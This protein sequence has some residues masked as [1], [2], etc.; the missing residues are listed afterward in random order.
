MKRILFFALL[1]LLPFAIPAQN[2]ATATYRKVDNKA[3]KRGETLRYRIHYGAINAGEADLVVDNSKTMINGRPTLH[4]VGTGESKGAFDW[5]FKVRDRYE[6]YLDEEALMPWLFL[7][8]VDEG[9]YKINQ[10][11][12]Y[13]HNSG[14]VKSNGKSITVP[15]Y[16]QDMLSSFYYARTMDFSKAKVG[17]IFSVKTFIDDEIWDLKIKYLGKE[18]VD[19][20]LGK[21]NCLKFCPIV[22][23]GRVFKKE[24]DLSLYISDDANHVPVRAM[25]DIAVGSIKMDLVGTSGLAADL[26][27]VK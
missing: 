27:K 7:R 17:D 10:N 23:K 12:A 14:T 3:F 6:S 16:I 2:A 26:N 4:V 22:Q 1:A 20:D 15:K 25:G 19:S 21:I 11:Q 9:G 5:V 13:D 8:K 18:A 24:E